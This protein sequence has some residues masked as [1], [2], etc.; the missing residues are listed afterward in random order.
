MLPL[1]DTAKLD[2]PDA[3]YLRTK[4]LFEK[5]YFQVII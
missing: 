3:A 1:F 2:K 5:N 4:K